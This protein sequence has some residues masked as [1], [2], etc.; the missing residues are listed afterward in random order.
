LYRNLIVASIALKCNT[1]I[2][3]T[4]RSSLF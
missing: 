3:P 1:E 4:P 2:P